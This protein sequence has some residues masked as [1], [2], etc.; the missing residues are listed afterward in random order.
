MF[1]VLLTFDKNEET[2]VPCICYIYKDPALFSNRQDAQ[3]Y[4]DELTTYNPGC[5]YEVKELV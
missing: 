1:T 2:L 3:A 4:V 5:V